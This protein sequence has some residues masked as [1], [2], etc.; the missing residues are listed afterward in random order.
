MSIFS[1]GD[2]LRKD[3]YR[4]APTMRELRLRTAYLSTISRPSRYL[5]GWRSRLQY[6]LRVSGRRDRIGSTPKVLHV[7]HQLTDVTCFSVYP[8]QLGDENEEAIESR[9]RS[10]FYRKLGF[11]PGR[12][13]LL[14]ITQREEE[15]IASK[16]GYR[17]S[18]R[19]S[20]ADWPPGMCFTSLATGRCGLW[21]T[22][23]ARNVG[24]SVQR[25]M[26]T[27]F[28][29]DPKNAPCHERS[30]GRILRVG[31]RNVERNRAGRV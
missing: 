18:A 28:G 20:F 8:Y 21:D 31:D 24:L 26:A 16:P 25:R 13:E 17:T 3:V 14:T 15:K 6:L 27:K 9:A 4:C 22:F 11:R 30:L 7:L 10:G 29:G 23:S 12:P 5:N 19:M 1:F 2:C